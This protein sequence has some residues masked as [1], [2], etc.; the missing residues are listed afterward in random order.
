MVLYATK[1]DETFVPASEL[2]AAGM[3]PEFA[4]LF[5]KQDPRDPLPVILASFT[6]AREADIVC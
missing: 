5:A 6:A 3:F 2:E 1:A 4:Q